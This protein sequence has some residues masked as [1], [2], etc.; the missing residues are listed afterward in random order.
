MS[1]PGRMKKAQRE[2][3]IDVVRTENQESEDERGHEALTDRPRAQISS[4]GP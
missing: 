4:Q 2:E 3:E 1:Q